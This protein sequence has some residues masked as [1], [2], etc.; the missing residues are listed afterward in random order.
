[1][2]RTKPPTSAE[3]ALVRV[4]LGAR[5]YDI[6]I[7]PG[8]IANAGALIGPHLARKRTAVVTDE[9]VAGLHLEPL[10]EALAAAGIAS[11]AVVVPPG[12]ATK[13]LDR[14]GRVIDQLLEA[15]VERRDRIVALG[16]GV[17][18][19]LA[20]FAAAIV[21]RGIGLIQVPT[22]LLAQVDSSVGGKTG[23][24]AARGKNLIGAFHQPAAVLADTSC[25]DTLPPREFAAGYA[26]IVKYGL[27]D[28]AGFFE[29]LAGSRQEIFGHG[30]ALTRAIET[31][32]RAK[33]RIVAADE[34]E[35]GQRALLNLGHTFAHAIEVA[36]GYS[37]RLRHGEAVAIGCCLAFALSARLGL[38]AAGDADRARDQFAAAGLPTGLGPLRSELPNAAGL[39]AL[40][41]RDKK[42]V[43][44]RM[45]L[46]LARGIGRAFV[47]D[48][49]DGAAL[50]AFL[51]DSLG[52]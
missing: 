51:E 44:G 15:G 10:R 29:W 33:A 42:V 20:G 12:E 7:G 1:M 6:H 21:H 35:A 31:S 30:P 28:D 48:E 27:I 50:A 41:G 16:G 23:V 46:V 49:V 24:N 4:E 14:A 18:G 43:D 2:L 36:L 45:T 8:L 11:S 34:R 3:T 5:A 37:D 19:D 38:C 32:C 40:M 25:L 13:S 9:T 47:T 17:V 22:T 39:L 26:E 52:C